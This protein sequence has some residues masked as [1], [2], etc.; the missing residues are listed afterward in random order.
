[1][2]CNENTCTCGHKSSLG[3][4]CDSDL[5]NEQC[6]SDNEMC[7]EYLE[8]NPD[9]CLCRGAPVIDNITPVGGFCQGDINTSCRQDSDC[10]DS[11]CDELTPN[12]APG[13]LITVS[14]RYFGT[15]TGEVYFSDGSGG[16]VLAPMPNEQNPDCEDNWN[17]GQVI[18]IVPE[19]AE[20]GPLS[21][22][23]VDGETDVTDNDRG[24]KLPDFVVNSIKRP[25]LCLLNP[26]EGSL[27]TQISYYGLN[28]AG[29]IGYFGSQTSN[30]R[31]KNSNFISPLSGTAEV[32]LLEAGETTSF[33]IKDDKNSNTLK[34]NKLEEPETGPVINYFDPLKGAPGQYVTIYGSGFGETGAGKT[35]YFGDEVTGIEADFD[36]PKVCSDSIWTNDQIIVKVPTGISN[37][38]YILS[39]DLVNEVINTEN[40]VSTETHSP[41]FTVDDSLSLKPGLCKIE[42][43][44]GPRNISISLWGE[45]FGQT[46]DTVRFYK[47]KNQTGEAIN[48]WGQDQDAQRVDT[49]V[50]MQ[51]ASGPVKVV[52][53]DLEGNG[54]NFRV[55]NCN[56]ADNPNTAC[57][58]QICCPGGTFKQGRCA[59]SQDQCLID[60]PTS[61]YEWEFNTNFK[62][63]IGDPCYINASTTPDC[64]PTDGTCV[65]GLFCN[66]DVCECQ[67][68]ESLYDSCQQRSQEEGNCNPV[69]C[70]NSPGECSFYDTEEC[71]PDCSSLSEC[72]SGECSYNQILDNCVI[73]HT[74]C[75]IATTTEEILGGEEQSY[76][77]FC[78]YNNG[79]TYWHIKTSRSCPDGWTNIGES[80][81]INEDTAGE[82]N[83]CNSGVCKETESGGVCAVNQYMCQEQ[84]QDVCECC[85]RLKNSTQDCCSFQVPE[86]YSAPED[87]DISDQGF[88][89]LMCQGNCG[90]DATETDT[91]TYGYCSG[92]RIED[93]NGVV[94]QVLSDQAC[95][96]EHTSGKYCDVEADPDRDGTL[97]GVCRDCVTI[98]DTE[99]CSV[100]HSTC[101]VDAMEDDRCT[102]GEGNLDMLAGDDPN[103]AYC[104]YY[105]CTD[106][107]DSCDV[108][109]NPVPESENEVY[110]N[111]DQCMTKCSL[112]PQ[113]GISCQGN[114]TSTCFTSI[115]PDPFQC[116]NKDGS[117]ASAPSACGT[118]CCHPGSNDCSNLNPNNP[119]LTCQPDQ[120][121]CTGSDRG[122]CC[123][124]D[125][126]LSC[127][128]KAELGCGSDS[129]CRSRPDISSTT[130]ADNADDICANTIISAKFDQTMNSESFSGN[131]LVVGEY[132]EAC[133]EGTEYL[134]FGDSKNNNSQENLLT[135]LSGRL[136]DLFTSFYFKISG[137]TVSANMPSEDFNYCAVSGSVSSRQ[138]AAERTEIVFNSNELL[139]TD[140]KYFVIVTGDENLDSSSGVLSQWNI[141]M[142]SR[143]TPINGSVSF[144]GKSYPHSYIWS[145]ITMSDQ[146]NKGVCEINK[147]EI[148]PASY[149]FQ[150]TDNDLNENDDDP[151]DST[152]D[153]E[154]DRDKVFIAKALTE[155]NK[156]IIGIPEYSWEWNWN[157]IDTKIATI[158]QAP[159]SS[160]DNK[161]L[162]K[163]TSGITNANTRVTA[164]VN[165]IN[166]TY[167]LA[168]DGVKGLAD[169]RVFLCDNPW[170]PI[171][172]DGTW[173]PWRDNAEGMNCIPGSGDCVPM[174][175]Q[176][177]YCRDSGSDN[178]A[179]DLPSIQSQDTKLRGQTHTMLKEAYFFRE[180]TPNAT[181]I[182][183]ATT[184]NSQIAK[185]NKVGLIWNNYAEINTPSGEEVSHYNVYYGTASGLPYNNSLEVDVSTSHTT[186]NPYIV[187]SLENGRKYFFTITA[188][189]SNGQESDFSNEILIIPRDTTGPVA[190]LIDEVTSRDGLVQVEWSDQ[191][192]GEAITFKLHYRA[193]DTCSAS[194]NFGKEISLPYSLS[195]TTTVSDLENG[196]NYCIG[197]TA[198]DEDGNSSAT[199]TSGVVA[200]SPEAE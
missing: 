21:L 79:Q 31:A 35:V 167:S 73:N 177:Y 92:C 183:L 102:G 135:F 78:D 98:T 93:E 55:G 87:F 130:P 90:S 42:P 197:M 72:A 41:T 150:T 192:N 91:D 173:Y 1:M 179:D 89:S 36:F 85:C 9:S 64:T 69:I 169:I 139:D 147:A 160:G 165:L 148:E 198:L 171:R 8:C 39:I 116:L 52:K 190:P 51:A 118:C 182:N 125:T 2:F 186:S 120:G 5:S 128:Y 154:K 27:N 170:P 62:G 161:Q 81:C 109:N 66:S 178:T 16:R 97:E 184:T 74:S 26:K 84:S 70:S 20:Q 22:I 95:V 162:I 100:H 111:V 123:G 3:E 108:E 103:L 58:E 43:T 152:F 180:E 80:Q 157:I 60:I 144:N 30:K 76:T 199:T 45:Y 106:T 127:G 67:A 115:C 193:S 12:G 10:S 158:Y 146:G 94:D 34:F 71:N 188:V 164:M 149:L 112:G 121:D 136:K 99:S 47:D 28:L 176:L 7:A 63:G 191:S 163:A 11:E 131:I 194:L 65:E 44:M 29:G 56:E 83:I 133:P 50:H 17:S 24:N 86:G 59:D 122:L 195:A 6:D 166:N 153:T 129:C 40:I 172:Q 113:L 134:T 19:G 124:C 105:Q 181:G 75:S 119:Y 126:D 88:L 14:G 96:C 77:K 141:G 4:P 174:N 61:V 137:K 37:G 25:G 143:N 132:S 68:E 57:G 101:C 196:V 46:K 54:M 13:N 187:E 185:G 82:C 156:E 15:S 114:A 189:Y 107:G 168:G 53:S 151:L 145:F 18:V 140:R 117:S 104:Q 32:P 200:P 155:N 48:Y 49:T 33:V 23:R 175:Y 110:S 38:N 138:S 159:F 142:N